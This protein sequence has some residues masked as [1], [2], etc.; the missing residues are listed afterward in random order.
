MNHLFLVYWRNRQAYLFLIQMLQ[1]FLGS[2][3]VLVLFC[4]FYSFLPSPDNLNL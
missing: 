2:S 1:V 4:L 3:S